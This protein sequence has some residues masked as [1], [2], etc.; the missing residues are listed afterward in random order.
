MDDFMPREFRSILADY[1]QV[2]LE[3]QRELKGVKGAE[4]SLYRINELIMK[5]SKY[6]P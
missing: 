2:L 3:V 4:T 1:K 5:L 6:V